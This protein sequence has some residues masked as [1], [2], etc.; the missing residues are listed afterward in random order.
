M[1][2][3]HSE[4]EEFD[5]KCLVTQIINKYKVTQKVSDELD[6]FSLNYKGGYYQLS[7]KLNSK[8]MKN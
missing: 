7:Q 5:K 4:E 2:Y 1:E 6:N 3:S 8:E